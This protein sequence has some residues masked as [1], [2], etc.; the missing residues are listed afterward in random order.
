MYKEG[1]FVSNTTR[2]CS[3]SKVPCQCAMLKANST[4][5]LWKIMILE[6]I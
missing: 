3:G 5:V 4:F 1:T 6:K 2:H